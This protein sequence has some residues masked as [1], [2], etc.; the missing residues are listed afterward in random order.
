VAPGKEQDRIQ[1][2]VI[3]N[4]ESLLRCLVGFCFRLL[5]FVLSNLCLTRGYRML[6]PGSV[7]GET[8]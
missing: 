2:W 4:F 5:F 1:L 7:L 8:L 3:D 6:P